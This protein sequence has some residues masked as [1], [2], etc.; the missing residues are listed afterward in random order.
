[1]ANLDHL[2]K[3]ADFQKRNTKIFRTLTALRRY[4]DRRA[5]NGLIET[6]AVVE[7]PLGLLIDEAKF[8][9]WLHSG[10]P[11]DRAA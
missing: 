3:P 8:A 6:G 5:V 7:S 2:T 1:M 11:R 10:T 9:E 4:L